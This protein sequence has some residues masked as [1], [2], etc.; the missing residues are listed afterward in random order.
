VDAKIAEIEKLEEMAKPVHP[1][2]AGRPSAP[3]PPAL[4]VQAAA[5]AGAAVLPLKP[6]APRKSKAT[7]PDYQT[8]DKATKEVFQD[9]SNT[10][11]MNA[12]EQEQKALKAYTGTEFSDM[13]D[14][15]YGKIPYD[16]YY[17]RQN[18]RLDRIIKKFKLKKD[19]ITYRGT[20]AS[21]YTDWEMDKTYTLPAFISTSIDKNN[22]IVNPDFIIEMR[23]KKGTR[24]MYIG[25]LSKHEEEDE[26]LLGRG[27]NYRVIEKTKNNMVLEVSND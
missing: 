18:K 24:G 13:N 15:L 7:K 21:H 22:E 12:S 16:A 9:I 19:I 11:Y 20:D 14:M 4:P 6:K 17:D 26:F 1:A 2:P 25:S 8:V 10:I 23:I 27:L 5:A 3:V